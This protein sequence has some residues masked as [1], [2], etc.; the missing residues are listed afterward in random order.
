MMKCGF[1]G[2]FQKYLKIRDDELFAKIENEAYKTDNKFLNAKITIWYEQVK[3]WI[4]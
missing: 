3:R 1:R 2:V 4:E